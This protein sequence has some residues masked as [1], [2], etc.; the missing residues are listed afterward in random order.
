MKIDVKLTS[1]LTRNYPGAP[2]P[3][4]SLKAVDAALNE[5][6]SFQIAAKTDGDAVVK[7]S[8]SAPEGWS[9]RVRRVGTVPVPHRNTG[10][11]AAPL[12]NEPAQAIPGFVPD[13]LF[14]ETSASVAAGESA[15][16]WVTATPP[17][18]A[19]PGR[20]ALT[21]TAAPFNIY[22]AD[23]PAGK[24][25]SR[26]LAATL[27][28]VRIAPR[29]GF[30][31]T[32]W[33][34]C[35]CLFDRYGTVNFD[36]RFWP[37]FE[38]YVRD[39]VQHGQNVLYV[40]LFTPPL[41]GV[42]RPTQLLKVS[43]AGKSRYKFG[44]DDVRRFVRI[45]KKCGIEKF[46]WC[47]LFAQWGCRHA[48]RIY[49]GQGLD[50]KLLWPEDTPATSGIYR[51]FLAQLLPELR[52]FLREE[53]IE[54]KSIFHISDEP[55]GDEAKA[56]YKAAKEML[57]S[58]AP[59]MKFCDAVSH[60]DFGKDHIIDVPVPVI[61]TALDFIGAGLECWC[62]YCCAPKGGYL[63]HLIDTPLAKVAMHGLLFYRWPFRGFLHWGLNYWNRRG[64][65][66]PIDPYATLDA[67]AW[68]VWSHGDTF[69]IYPGEDGPVDSIRWEVFAE[70]MQDYAL[71]Q[72][73][74]VGR[75]DPLLR[76]LK[77][78]SDFPKDASWRLA[79]RRRLFARADRAGAPG[80][81]PR[82]SNRA[83]GRR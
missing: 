62:Y 47:H 18:D 23:E 78:F 28:N 26:K 63:Q 66:I 29:R 38:A 10:S 19:E 41:D 48:L 59:E 72:T 58:L 4:A 36:E 60:L 49:A 1:S 15:V 6:F 33:F 2:L 12:D 44:W 81:A 55:D 3:S 76:P 11:S 53:R 8:V 52:R 43:R 14:D 56:N 67:H 74:G 46:E 65:R 82:K 37:L 34:Y 51:D 27:H 79:L 70:S 77:S 69:L 54:G 71:L 25:V 32:F 7:A 35:D 75:D 16:F 30:D 24:P 57:L 45:A 39:I 31:I 42:K 73:L 20:F 17:P 40:P 68:P 83:A 50:E 21:A 22:N 80:K 61:Y 5:R 13:P 9:V 64:T